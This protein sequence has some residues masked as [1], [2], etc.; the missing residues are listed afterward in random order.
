MHLM[1]GSW[2]CKDWSSMKLNGTKKGSTQ[3]T[4]DGTMAT[5]RQVRPRWW[6]GE[7]LED[8]VDI[9]SALQSD[10]SQVLFVFLSPGWWEHPK[11]SEYV[12]LASRVPGH[13]SST[14]E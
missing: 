12:I 14:L 8:M 6:I 10:I 9:T 5:L 3:S 1:V 13:V 2:S 11:S 7:N 4:F